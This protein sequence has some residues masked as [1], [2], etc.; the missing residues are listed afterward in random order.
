MITTTLKENQN[1]KRRILYRPLPWPMR[2]LTWLMIV[3]QVAL[4]VTPQMV[5][6]ASMPVQIPQ[7][8]DRFATP[9]PAPEVTVNRAVPNVTPVPAKFS[10]SGA[11]TDTEISQ[12][13]VFGLPLIPVGS[14]TLEENKALAKALAEF[15][16]RT[17]NDNVEALADFL[18][19][20]PNSN[21]KASLL[22]NLGIFY[23]HTGW[24]TRALDA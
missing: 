7:S 5:M 14:T 9:L 15:R 3:L 8:I 22:L 21:W 16:N 12:S 11:P 23:R 13:H 10:F 18:N 24:F 20:H 19:S 2:V 6:A 4:P 17:N 1:R